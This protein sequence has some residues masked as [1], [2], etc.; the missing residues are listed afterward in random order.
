MTLGSPLAK[1][2]AA[3]IVGTGTALAVVTVVTALMPTPGTATVDQAA[4]VGATIILTVAWFSANAL[5]RLGYLPRFLS[6][7]PYAL[8]CVVA[9]KALVVDLPTATPSLACRSSGP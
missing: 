5:A 2:A 8:G 3:G 9:A 6:T 7:Y 1:A 4:Q